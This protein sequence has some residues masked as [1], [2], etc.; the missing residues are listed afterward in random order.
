VHIR[1]GARAALHDV[2][3]ELI[4]ELAALD[5][6][7]DSID[8]ERLRAIE[9]ADLGIRP[10]CGLLDAGIAED[11]IR[12]VGDRTPADREV[13]DRAAD[14]D[15]PVDIRGY[16]LLAKAVD[17][18]TR[19]AP[20]ERGRPDALA[21]RTL[22]TF[23]G[24]DPLVLVPH[25]IHPAPRSCSR[26]AQGSVAAVRGFRGFKRFSAVCGWREPRIRRVGAAISLWSNDPAVTLDYA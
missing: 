3:D 18:A 11:Q 15:A 2:D 20:S 5:L 8:Q 6:L 14:V 9:H 19:C 16:E 10:C 24:H 17:L 22:R 21:K 13:L 4:V 25:R 1:R 7:A 12:I 26:G 23:I